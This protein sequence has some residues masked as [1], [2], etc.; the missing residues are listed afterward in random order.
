M[1]DFA[2]YFKHDVL[3][4]ALEGRST[5][6]STRNVPEIHDKSQVLTFLRRNRR[7]IERRVPFKKGG[8]PCEVYASLMSEKKST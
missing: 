2:R 1:Y 6:T 7:W 8:K 4:S 5:Q 3:S